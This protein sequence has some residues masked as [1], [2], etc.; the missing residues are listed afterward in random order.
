LLGAAAKESLSS[1]E[2]GLHSYYPWPDLHASSNRHRS[3]C[4]ECD[5]CPSRRTGLVLQRYR[6]PRT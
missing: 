3:G 4:N 5:S 2:G 1:Q 6:K